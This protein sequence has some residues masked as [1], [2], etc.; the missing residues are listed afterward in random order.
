MLQN[1]KTDK[2]KVLFILKDSKHIT[3]GLYKMN[4]YVY[5]SNLIRNSFSSRYLILYRSDTNVEFLR[6][7]R[8]FFSLI[9]LLFKVV[10][11]IIY[12]RPDAVYFFISPV[13]AFLRDFPIVCLLK[14]SKIDIVYHLQGRG[15]KVKYEGSKIYKKMFKFVYSNE[16]VIV[17]S[18]KL[19]YD[20]DYLPVKKIF[21]IPNAADLFNQSNLKNVITKNEDSVQLLYLSN[22][23]RE[24]GIIEFIEASIILIEKNYMIESL[25]V[26]K[27]YDVTSD[28]I[29][30]LIAGFEN[31]I[32]Y[33]GPKF[34]SE[35]LHIFDESDIFVFPTY[36]KTEALS[37]VILEAMQAGLPIVTTNEAALTDVIKD[38]INGFITKKRDA[39]DLSKKIEKLI[40]NPNLRKQMGQLNKKEFLDKYTIDKFEENVVSVL[41]EVCSK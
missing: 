18:D 30:K 29:S 21:V 32:H 39:L 31:K 12:Y 27:E 26:G 1:N 20:V 10:Y 33:I 3:H 38:G 4:R 5:N 8:T 2:K 11:E 35:K 13:N 40:K 7:I 25:I 6:Y 19:K 14:I 9:S 22:L 17:L 28:E 16:N 37:L 24:K 23:I 15:I 36:Y 41:N 34:N